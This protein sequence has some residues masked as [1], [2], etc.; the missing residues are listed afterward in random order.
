MVQLI[1]F[2]AN[3]VDELDGLCAFGQDTHRP[4]EIMHVPS[5]I[6]SHKELLY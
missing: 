2:F 4:R 1:F 3:Y 6:N 5:I